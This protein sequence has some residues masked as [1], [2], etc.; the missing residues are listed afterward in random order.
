LQHQLLAAREAL[1]DQATHDGLTGLLNHNTILE[2]VSKEMAR[3][4]R[5]GH[6]LSLLMVDVDRFKQ[7]NDTHGH[8]A[9]DAILRESARRMRETIRSYD[10]V[11]RYGGEEFLIVLPGCDGES[12]V[13]Q[14]ERV[15]EVFAHAPFFIGQHSVVV[16]C[17][18]GAGSISHPF[19]TDGE[20]LLREADLALYRAK[21]GGRNRVEGV[22][23]HD[24]C[25][26][27]HQL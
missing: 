18:I 26:L 10:S 21:E 1:R 4:S 27:S 20:T 6:A 22:A 17:S 23:M 2:T 5:E 24:A 25:E 3:A 9:G 11:G 19:E 16:T 12:A 15:R 7:I 14:A 8:A 13:T